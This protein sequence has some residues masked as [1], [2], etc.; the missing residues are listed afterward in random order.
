MNTI[1]LGE[2]GRGVDLAL[3]AFNISLDECWGKYF[4]ARKIKI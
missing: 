1:S 3:T 4:N 2:G